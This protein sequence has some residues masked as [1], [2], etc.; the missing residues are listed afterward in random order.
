MGCE[1]H[2]SFHRSVKSMPVVPSELGVG[3]VERRVSVCLGLLDAARRNANQQVSW[4]IKKPSI[5]SGKGQPSHLVMR[6]VDA[7]LGHAYPFLW[8]FFD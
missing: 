6:A 4:V 5:G 1:T 7:K 2:Q 3:A 8:F